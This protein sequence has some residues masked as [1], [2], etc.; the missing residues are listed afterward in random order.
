MNRQ[1]QAILTIG[2]L[3]FSGCGGHEERQQDI[4][5]RRAAAEGVYEA[6]LETRK[7][8]DS[9]EER[10]AITREFLDQHAES[11]RTARAIDAVFYY[12][13]EQLGDTMGAV[14]YIEGIRDQIDDPEIA[15]TVDRVMIAV[16]AKAGMVGEMAALAR[17]LAAV[18]DFEDHWNVIEGAVRA[19]D[20]ELARDYCT[21]AR[22]MASAEGVKA[23][24]PERGF[25]DAELTAEVNDRVGRLLVKNGWARANQGETKE[26]LAD[27]EKADGM[28]PRYYFDIP[29]Y[30]L[31]V[32]WARTL[33]TVG[34]FEAAIERLAM[35]AL[36][37]RN[38]AAMTA[39]R[40][41]YLG[42][43]GSAAGFDAYADE[44]HGKVA[45]TVD[46]FTMPDYDGVRHAFSDLRGEVT[47]LTLWFP[48]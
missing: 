39:L 27:F 12:Q 38:E 7:V 3:A 9:M 23:E 15:E 6:L 45:P 22:D 30:G 16:Y 19:E 48:T 35:D 32:H 44:L 17:R 13:A 28:I 10:L 40:D 37:M 29:E 14:T 26:A 8:M 25:S 18:L 5:S 21:R 47:L 42:L 20:W 43:N 24:F 46:D 11:A 33:I 4:A 2:V 34:Q 41:A 1:L 36:V 31:N